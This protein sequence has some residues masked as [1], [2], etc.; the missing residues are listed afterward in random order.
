MN[1]QTLFIGM[2]PTLRLRIE[3]T[4]ENLLSLLDEIDG[5]EN[6]EPYHAGFD[7]RTMDDREGDD[8]REAIDEREDDHGDYDGPGFISG[9]QGL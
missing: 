6:L 9:G 4:I 2:T 5:D 8:E 1:R 7:Q 3:T